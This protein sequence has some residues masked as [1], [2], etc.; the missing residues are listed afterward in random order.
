VGISFVGSKTF[1][2]AAITAQSCSLTDLKDE[3][4]N[5]ATLLEGDHVFIGYV[6]ASTVDRTQ[7]QQTPSGYTALH[8]DE[9]RNDS[10]DVNLLVSVKEMGASPDTTVSIPASNATT[11][12]CSVVIVALRG[13]DPA[14]VNDVAAVATG[15]TNTGIANGG[16]IT[17][18]TAG[19]WILVFAGAAVAAGAVF[20]NPSG[21]STTTNH[22][23]SATITTTTNDANA[24]VAIKTDWTSG[25]VDPAAFGGSTSTNTGSWATATLAIRPLLDAISATASPVMDSFL[26]AGGAKGIAEGIGSATLNAFTVTATATVSDAHIVASAAPELTEFTVIATVKAIASAIATPSLD[27][28]ISSAAAKALIEGSGGGVLNAFVTTATVSVRASAAASP[29]LDAFGT[30]AAV[31]AVASATANPSLDAFTVAATASV[32]AKLSATP[33]LDSFLSTAAA[34]AL[35][36][37]VGEGILNAFQS[38]GA[39]TVRA[40]ATGLVVLDEFTVS[41]TAAIRANLAVD[42]ELDPFISTAA[43]KALVEGVG[44]ATLN[45]FSVDASA[46]VRIVAAAAPALAPFT[47]S[48]TL[49]SGPSTITAWMEQDLGEFSVTAAGRVR[50]KAS[51]APVIS[52]FTLAASLSPPLVVAD[53]FFVTPNKRAKV[54]APCQCPKVLRP[55]VIRRIIFAEVSVMSITNKPWVSKWAGETDYRGVDW[56]TE[57]LSGETIVDYDFVPEEGSGVVVEDKSLSGLKTIALLSGG[58]AGATVKVM[59]SVS[60]SIPRLLEMEIEFPIV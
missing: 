2:H 30:T 27:T 10:N 16:A 11:A 50:I 14:S 49:G 7:A 48:S 38:S 47:V 29:S 57:L 4:N 17:P 52:T 44:S 58:T 40:V 26:S 22:F 13:V 39:I 8:T 43:A 53:A 46:T 59:A 55:T 28:F 45:P 31:K 5:N 42:C 36:E 21:M 35:I 33:A 60:T 32:P 12:G 6:L 34:Q 41:A 25:S 9:Y 56:K 3:S 1:T 15:G 20:T 18:S 37:G 51:A 23:R 24:A 19:A 54:I